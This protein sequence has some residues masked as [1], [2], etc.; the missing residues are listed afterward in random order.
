MIGDY[1]KYKC[2]GNYS[3]PRKSNVKIHIEG[4]NDPMKDII[5]RIPVISIN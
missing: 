3:Y 1:L 5:K 2:L 4:P